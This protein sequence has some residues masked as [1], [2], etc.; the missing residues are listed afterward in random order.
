M[1]FI[2]DCKEDAVYACAIKCLTTIR[3]LHPCSDGDI[4]N[5]ILNQKPCVMGQGGWYSVGALILYAIMFAMS[6]ALP[7]DDP[8]GFFCQGR[9]S[10]ETAGF[11]MLGSS[12]TKNENGENGN[13]QNG[14]P[15]QPNWL[16]EESKPTVDEENEIIQNKRKNYCRDSMILFLAFL[17]RN[18]KTTLM[19]KRC[20][21]DMI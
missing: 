17:E 16:S 6:C 11:G 9:D 5:E 10:K 20:D 18:Q 14:K 21:Y 2:Y 3:F 1:I 7:Q 15:Q 8:H 12:V 4:I 19:Q 13:P